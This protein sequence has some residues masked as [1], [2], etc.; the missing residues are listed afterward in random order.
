MKNNP[1]KDESHLQ[2]NKNTGHS[3]RY[4]EYTGKKKREIKNKKY[5]K[6]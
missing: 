4:K 2:N 5:K 1:Q 6:N 3:K